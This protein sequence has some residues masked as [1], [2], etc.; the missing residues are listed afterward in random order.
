MKSRVIDADLEAELRDRLLYREL[1]AG[2]ARAER[3]EDVGSFARQDV[4]GSSEEQL[5]AGRR[6]GRVRDDRV[7]LSLD[8]LAKVV[9]HAPKPE[10]S[11]VELIVDESKET[12]VDINHDE[13]LDPHAER[14]G[15]PKQCD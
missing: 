11:I 2:P 4:P 14:T 3:E 6:V 13:L 5:G 7:E 9:S 10:W 8:R 1:N 15:E 12:L